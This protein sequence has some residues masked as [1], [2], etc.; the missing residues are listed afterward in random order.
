[1]LEVS[2]E[3]VASLMENHF[4]GEPD[5]L[6][7]RDN[8]GQLYKVT[9]GPYPH[10]FIERNDETICVRG[11]VVF[12]LTRDVKTF[13]PDSLKEFLDVHVAYSPNCDDFK[14]KKFDEFM[15]IVFGTNV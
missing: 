3:D 15:K 2:G 11:R 8:K 13:T 4:V 12:A 1:M 10:F 9:C 7:T 6:W 5:V 14:V